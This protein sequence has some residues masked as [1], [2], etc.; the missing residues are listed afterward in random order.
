MVLG[1]IAARAGGADLAAQFRTQIIDPMHLHSAGY[2]PAPNISGR[3]SES[4]P[5][6]ASLRIAR[7]PE[8]KCWRALPQRR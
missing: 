6:E 3:T 4:R 2:D 7:S 5:A 1:L 8:Q